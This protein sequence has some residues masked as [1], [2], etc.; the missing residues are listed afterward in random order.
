M[1]LGSVSGWKKERSPRDRGM[2][3]PVKTAGIYFPSHAQFLDVW[4]FREPSGRI[5]KINPGMKRM[6]AVGLTT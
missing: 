6:E 2:M 3:T 1:T 4:C 5:K